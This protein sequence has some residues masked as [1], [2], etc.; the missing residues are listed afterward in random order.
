MEMRMLLISYTK[1]GGS[2]TR[3]KSLITSENSIVNRNFRV[4]FRFMIRKL[5]TPQG[6]TKQKTRAGAC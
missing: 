4:E 1:K 3:I 2:D 6:K 5:G